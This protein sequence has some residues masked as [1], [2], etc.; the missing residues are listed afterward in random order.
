MP[1]GVARKTILLLGALLLAALTAGLL[2][3]VELPASAQTAGLSLT[4]SDNPDPVFVGETLTYTLEVVNNGTN[5]ANNVTI[6]DTL[7][8][9]V[10]FNSA[11]FTNGS[12]TGNC[13]QASGTVT[14]NLGNLERNARATVTIR[15][16]PTQ[17]G[18]ITNRASARADNRP[19]VTAT[20][21]TTVQSPLTLTKTDDPDPVTVGQDLTYTLTVTNRANDKAKDVTV[22][23]TLPSGVTFVSATP[24]QGNCTQ[25]GGTVTCDLGDLDE[26]Q[27]ATVMIVVRPTQA[28]TIT[29]T[30]S[31]SAKE[32][33]TVTVSEQT[34]VRAADLS[35]SKEDAPDPVLVNGDF[36]YTLPC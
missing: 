34:T 6:T 16:T 13:T 27:S 23:D 10:T 25:S 18:E 32:S 2:V 20:A 22:T 28:G 14:C 12:T 30:A 21:S 8:S 31:A 4:K 24:S 3:L 9:G 26:G 7:P 5:R 15:V 11:T 19:T 17:P 36:S 1:I 35:I 33:D 29:N